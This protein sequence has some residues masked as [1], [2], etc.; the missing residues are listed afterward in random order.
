MVSDPAC[1]EGNNT[2]D[3]FVSGFSSRLTVNCGVTGIWL[4]MSTA[5]FGEMRA[6]WADCAASGLAYCAPSR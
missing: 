2:A 1:L 4:S 6:Y 3:P 5:V